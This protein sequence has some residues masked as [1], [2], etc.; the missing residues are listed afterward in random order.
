MK[1]LNVLE[2]FFQKKEWSLNDV[3]TSFNIILKLIEKT[4]KQ[5]DPVKAIK[6]V[7]IIIK[8]WYNKLAQQ[9]HLIQKEGAER[10]LRILQEYANAIIQKLNEAQR[11]IDVK[12]RAVEINKQAE[13][14]KSY[15]EAIKTMKMIKNVKDLL[16]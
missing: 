12:K 7:C 15:L 1:A 11:T 16:Y 2:S 3:K 14:T 8:H 4:P 5:Q 10:Y 9:Q 13:Y 6:D